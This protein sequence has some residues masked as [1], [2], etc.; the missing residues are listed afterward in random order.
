MVQMSVIYQGDKHCELTHGPSGTKISTDAPKDNNGRGEAFSP[1]DLCA[2]SLATCALTVM[3]IAAEKE[4]ISLQGATASVT[5]EMQAE[6]RQ[7]SR[8][9]LALHLPRALTPD[10]RAK[11][12][13]IA[14][15]CPVKRSLNPDIKIA[16][17]FA[18]DI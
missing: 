9:G 7:I 1:T 2:V 16:T 12:E 18:Y 11:L 10:W 3:A 4:N 14:M 15:N 6:P 8:I 13:A 17:T 5:K